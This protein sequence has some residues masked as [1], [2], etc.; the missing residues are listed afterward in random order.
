MV[1]SMLPQAGKH[2][3]LADLS[4]TPNKTD[5]VANFSAWCHVT[6]IF[7][8]DFYRSE[9]QFYRRGSGFPNRQLGSLYWQLE[10]IWQAPTWAGIEYDGRWKVLHY[11]AK[12]IYEPV[13]ISP[14]YNITTGDLSI[15]VTS[16][17]WS[18]A[19]G[20][21]TL[22]WFTWDGTPI[23][24]L[25]TP[26]TVDF[27]VGAINTTL[28]FSTNTQNLSVDFDNAVLYLNVSAQGS[29]PNTNTTRTFNHENFFH[30]NS[31]AQAK[32]VD[33]GIQLSYSND[34]KNFTVEATSGIAAWTWLDYPAGP[35]LNFDN[36]GFLLLPGHPKEV[37]YTLK[38]D[39]TDGDWV[40][41]V[42]VQSLWNN[43]LPY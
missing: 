14:F 33:P 2:T 26:R 25:S 11:G 38:S 29:L 30:A 22:Q 16:D 9:I 24:N 4:Q 31:L 17:L 1:S 27:A 8:A 3:T 36:N 19:T 15:Y 32:L 5:S 23:N 13:I 20:M 34:T 12:D 41:D 7:Q 43:T 21:A 10:D 42:T 35:L 37:G 39:P 28:V 18:M 6:Q 40:E